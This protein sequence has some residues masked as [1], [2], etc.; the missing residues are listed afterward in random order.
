MI[1][2][3]VIGA[4]VA[5]QA[6]KGLAERMRGGGRSLSRVADLES[7]PNLHAVLAGSL[8]FQVG[9]EAGSDSLLFTI[10]LMLTLVLLYDTSGVK[11]AAG[12]QAW[13]LNRIR[14]MRAGQMPLP[15]IPGQ[16]T[17]R[18]WAAALFGA[19]TGL[20]LERALLALSGRLW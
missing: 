10:T 6:L 2:L 8:C 16:S 12:Q 15:E 19:V 7:F 3:P 13:V 20:G 1:L 5:G 4:G 17:L 14:E 18:A 11:R 9:E